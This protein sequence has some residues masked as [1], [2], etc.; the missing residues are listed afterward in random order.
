[1]CARP[2]QKRS[3]IVRRSWLAGAPGRGAGARD[4]KAGQ[5]DCAGGVV[6]LESTA[7]RMG[8]RSSARSGISPSSHSWA[9]LTEID[10]NDRS[11]GRA[12]LACATGAPSGSAG[13]EKH[14]AA[15]LE[16]PHD[17]KH[18]G[19]DQRPPD[20]R[21]DRTDV[22]ERARLPADLV[23]TEDTAE[24]LD[25][26]VAHAQDERDDRVVLV[27]REQQEDDP[28]HDQRLEDPEQKR[29]DPPQ[30]GE[31]R[32]SGVDDGG[33]V[34]DESS[35]VRHLHSPFCAGPTATSVRSAAPT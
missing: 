6:T 21:N 28:Q 20:E 27:R 30:D 11:P 7:A 29:D 1:M 5:A 15:P 18:E 16:D 9:A 32:R 25:E 13:S 22:E 3:R 17:A 14:R 12:R 23:E 4:T 10:E 24:W 31:S 8:L 26:R 33:V 2:R 19:L 34:A 35:F